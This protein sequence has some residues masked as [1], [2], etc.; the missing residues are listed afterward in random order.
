MI[1][2]DREYPEAARALSR[3][4]GEIVVVPNCCDLATDTACGDVR[5]AQVRGRAFETAMGI[6]V[7]NNGRRLA[8][9]LAR[10][11]RSRG[12]PCETP[13]GSV[14]LAALTGFGRSPASPVA[15]AIARSCA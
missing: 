4:G 3:R 9:A 11:I 15:N 10:D 13:R 6:A 8:G 2:M 5:I 14:S 12:D 1:C 7:A